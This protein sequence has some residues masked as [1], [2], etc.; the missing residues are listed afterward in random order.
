MDPSVGQASLSKSG[1]PQH[2]SNFVGMFKRPKKRKEYRVERS[3]G[4]D[5]IFCKADVPQG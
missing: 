3:L 4:M 2:C 1:V 5:F